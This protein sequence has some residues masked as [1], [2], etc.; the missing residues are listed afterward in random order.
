MPF[1]GI[2]S[3]VYLHSDNMALQDNQNFLKTKFCT[4][5][6]HGLKCVELVPCS[7]LTQGSELGNTGHTYMGNIRAIHR[8]THAMTSVAFSGILGSF[9][10]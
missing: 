1:F 6:L 3:L 10:V 2:L 8:K 7:I 9:L 4:L 5:I